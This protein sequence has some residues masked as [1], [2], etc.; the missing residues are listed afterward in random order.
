MTLHDPSQQP[1]PVPPT[2]PEP[3]SA[4]EPEAPAPAESIADHASQFSPSRKDAGDVGDIPKT[5]ANTG[6]FANKD[7]RKHVASSQRATPEDVAEINK[8]TKELRELETKVADKDPDAKSAPRLRTLKRQI[9]ALRALDAPPAPEPK[10]V[11][12][13]TPKPR[14]AVASTFDAKKPDINDFANDPDPVAAWTE[15]MM[16]WKADKREFDRTQ[17]QATEAQQREHQEIADKAIQSLNEFAKA[18]PDFQQVT[19]KFISE[20]VLPPVLLNAILK[21]DKQGAFVYHLGQHSDLADE[22]VFLTD[23]KPLTDAN[24]ATVQRRLTKELQ[25]LAAPT[26]S[27]PPPRPFTPPTPPNLVRTGPVK[28]DDEPPGEGASIADHKR[29]YA[30]GR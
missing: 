26:R 19:A 22:L 1:D 27:A 17:V 21:S 6:Q 4:P 16:D 8:L 30:K 15:A 5:P 10:P 7:G 13:E 2:I 12:R 3:T 23:G 9:A 11:P 18:Q 29:F 25:G 24:V 20:T 14:E 28:A